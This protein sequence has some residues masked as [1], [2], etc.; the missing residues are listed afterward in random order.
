MAEHIKLPT[1][2]VFVTYKYEGDDEECVVPVGSVSTK[3]MAA[4]VL[5]IVA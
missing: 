1:R 4:Y 5:R 3:E 2:E